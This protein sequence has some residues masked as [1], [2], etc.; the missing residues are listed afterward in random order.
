MVRAHGR[1]RSPASWRA[2]LAA[3]AVG[4]G[5]GTAL[6]LGVLMN[7]RGLTELVVLDIGLELG[8]LGPELFTMLVIMALVS[9]AMAAPIVGRLRTRAA[10]ER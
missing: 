7:C 2:L 9:T 3:R 1:C 10:A 8:V 5:W 6:Q 4:T